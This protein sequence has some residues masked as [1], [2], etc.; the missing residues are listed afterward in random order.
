LFEAEVL[1]TGTED[2]CYALER[3][4]R[5]HAGIGWNL[6]AG[7][8]AGYTRTHCEATREKMRKPKTEEHKRKTGLGNKGKVRTP[9][10]IEVIRQSRLGKPLSVQARAKVGAATR[11]RIRINGHHLKGTK[12]SKEAIAKMK[13]TVAARQNSKPDGISISS[14]AVELTV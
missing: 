9:E 8:P 1:F 13:A 2:Q 10:Q 6:T 12:R 5:P 14:S 11:E 7:G 3:E 4:L